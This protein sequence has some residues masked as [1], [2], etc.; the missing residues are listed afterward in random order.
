[1]Q[2]YV[3]DLLRPV[4][5]FCTRSA[6]AAIYTL[7]LH[8]ALP[9]CQRPRKLPW[10]RRTTSSSPARKRC[11]WCGWWRRWK[12]T[13]TCNTFTPTSTLTNRRSRRRWART[14]VRSTFS[15]FKGC[16]HCENAVAVSIFG[17]SVTRKLTHSHAL[18]LSARLELGKQCVHKEVARE[19]R[20]P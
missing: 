11:K 2:L 13:T 4:L 10:C 15:K 14:S 19:T 7:S 9:I 6:T 1:F 18:E 12:N 20:S 5:S 16:G 8:D 17:R 3:A